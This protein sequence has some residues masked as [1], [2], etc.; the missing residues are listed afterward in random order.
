MTHLKLLSLYKGEREMPDEAV[1]P[2][3]L[4]DNVWVVG[5]P[6][7]VTEKLRQMYREVGGFGVLL[8]MGHEWKPEDKWVS[9]MTRLA[10]EVMPR[11]ADLA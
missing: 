7:D 4:V 2:E 11:L 10:R 8:A 3:Y 9:S 6:D 1:T 5:S